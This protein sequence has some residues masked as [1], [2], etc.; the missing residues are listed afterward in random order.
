MQIDHIDVEMEGNA[1]NWIS[2]C[3]CVCV[4]NDIVIHQTENSLAE[5]KCFDQA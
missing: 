5:T 4:L 2:V 1:A 3:V